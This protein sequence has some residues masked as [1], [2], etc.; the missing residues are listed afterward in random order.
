MKGS[1]GAE[2]I[3]GDMAKPLNHDSPWKDTIEQ[4]TRSFLEV[5]F[6]EVAAGID[7]SVQ[8]ESLEQ[9]LRE[10]TPASEVGAKRVDKLLKVRLLDGT[11]QWLY[12][13]IEVQMHYD[14]DLPKRLFIYHYRIFDKYGV[15]PLTLAI[16]GDTSRKWRP[17]SYHYQSLGCGITFLFLICK[18]IDFK[19]KLDDPRY[20]HQQTL[21]VIA[22]HLGTQEHRRNPQNLFACLLEL[23]VKL[24]NEGYSP[25]EIQQLHRLIDWLMPLPDD[26]KIQFRNQLQQ[27]L[28]DKTMPH[29]TL[30]EELALKEG[31]EKG[32]Q[33]G[34]L[35]GLEKGI[36]KGIQKGLL[37]GRQ[38]GLE[39][40]IVQTAREAI[41]DVLDSRFGEVP[42]SV[43]ERINTLDD[44]R[45][46]RDLLRRAARVPSLAEF[47]VGL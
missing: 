42:D 13:H 45:T 41:L 1:V 9:E 36:Q 39:K 46:L 3:T 17:T 18:T 35:E 33:K 47:S 32:I 26:L 37:E 11:D 27:R 19:G 6:P 38:E 23:T 25:S 31:L 16:L 34:L 8:P 40:G 43:R 14:P 15:S 24:G 22:A 5:T 30:F 44:D 21:F 2:R 29:I 7:W 20:R 10:I 12:I 28:T 4:F